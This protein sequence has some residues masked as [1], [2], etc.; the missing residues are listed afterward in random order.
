[1]N[2]YIIENV[3]NKA[4]LL[5]VFFFCLGSVLSPAAA[6]HAQLPTETPFPNGHTVTDEFLTFYQKAA[7]PEQVYGL[8]LTDAFQD[9]ES[10]LQIQYFQKARFELHPEASAELRVQLTPLGYYLYTP[11]PSLIN[12]ANISAC[13]TFSETGFA[14]CHSFLTYY[15]AHGGA[16]QFGFP[17]SNYEMQGGRIVQY[18][19]LARL[20][21]WPEKAHGQRVVVGSLGEE[22]FKLR[23][24]NPALLTP[25]LGGYTAVSVLRLQVRAFP[26]HAVVGPSGR[27]TVNVIVLD[28]N[29]RQVANAQVYVT[30]R[31]PQRPERS[32][33]LNV[34]DGNGLTHIDFDYQTDALGIALVTVEATYDNLKTVTTT[35]FRIWY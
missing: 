25:N 6:S 21:W 2:L 26:L 23:G 17:I 30:V 1:M 22:Y 13:Q 16:A 24:E 31:V 19:Q 28:Q 35:S 10:G 20:E 29:L 15:Q 33:I 7:A 18:F 8:P 32:Y 14:V 12:P 5:L 4:R 9:P 27:Q 3:S 11:T 34:S